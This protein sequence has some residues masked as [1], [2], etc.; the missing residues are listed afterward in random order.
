MMQK[1]LLGQLAATSRKDVLHI[2]SN[3]STAKILFVGDTFGYENDIKIYRMIPV[4]AL[5]P[6][7]EVMESDINGDMNEFMQKYSVYLN[8]EEAKMYFAAIVTALHRGKNIL[9]FFPP[10][11]SGLKYQQALLDIISYNFGIVANTD[12]T[13]FAYNENYNQQNLNMMYY[14]NTISPQE[15]LLLSNNMFDSMMNKLLYDMK[16][17]VG[18]NTDK[19]TVY[20][21]LNQY[22]IDMKTKDK[23]LIKPF[24]REI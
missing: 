11:A 6:N 7:Y 10:E 2:L 19:K 22:R 20:D 21:Y 18:A 13:H 23:I 9:I 4:P 15:Y 24:V 8:S 14:Y 5:T 1:F 16:I 17:P 3:D 12:N